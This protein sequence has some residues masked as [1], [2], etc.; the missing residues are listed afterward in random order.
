MLILFAWL[1]SARSVLPELE[2]VFG[3][4]TLVRRIMEQYNHTSISL[5]RTEEFQMPPKLTVVLLAISVFALSRIPLA[6]VNEPK[7]LFGSGKTDL[8]ELG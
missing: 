7:M 1:G 3:S 4:L 2:S 6:H 5:S 8:A